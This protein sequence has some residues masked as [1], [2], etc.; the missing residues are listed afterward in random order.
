MPFSYA[1]R[2]GY[3]T[4][5]ENSLRDAGGAPA[6]G[7]CS[8]FFLEEF[9]LSNEDGIMEV[10]LQPSM[11]NN[12]WQPSADTDDL[13]ADV[14]RFPGAIRGE[15]GSLLQ[16][17]GREACAVPQPQTEATGGGAVASAQE[18]TLPIER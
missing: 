12:S 9:G 18:G 7:S 4:V 10:G 14:E 2:L 6:S 3:S 1:E 8:T 11:R 5:P 13:D 17:G 16:L 15:R